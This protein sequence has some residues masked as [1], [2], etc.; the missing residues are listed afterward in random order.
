MKAR[1]KFTKTG[2]MK[3]IGHLDIMRY[4][5]K[6]FRRADIDIAYSQGFNRHQLMSFAQPLG[7]G[8]TSDG[9]YLDVELNSCDSDEEMVARL[10]AQMND[11]IRVVK[12][13]KLGDNGR[14]AMSIVS[15]A[16]YEISLKDGYTPVENFEEKFAA[17]ASQE[18]IEVEKKTKKSSS[19]VDIK[20]FIYHYAFDKEAFG[21]LV[22]RD[23]TNTVA[24]EYDVQQKVYLQLVAGSVTNIKPDLVMEAFYQY[25]GQELYEFSYQYHRF[26]L[27]ADGEKDGELISLGK[28]DQ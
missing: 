27:Y 21:K 22:G 11:E 15:A 25:L 28:L 1:I 13:H 24:Q 6:A 7:V 10:N 3:F 18:K 16:D 19:I 9:E 26:D 12:F 4:F 5:Q 14:N 23:Y 2:S 8:L 20:P 17:F